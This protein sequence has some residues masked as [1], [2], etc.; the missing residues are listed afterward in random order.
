MKRI[1][2]AS[3]VIV[4]AFSALGGASV[5]DAQDPDSDRYE[6]LVRYFH[7]QITREELEEALAPPAELLPATTTDAATRVSNDGQT[8]GL[9][10][11]TERDRG[12]IFTTGSLANNG[13][14]RITSVTLEFAFTG[15]PTL[16]TYSLGLYA[17]SGSPPNPT[18]SALGTF[19]VSGTLSAGVNT[20]TLDG[21]TPLSLQPNTAYA[22]IFDVTALAS[23]N[24][25]DVR[26]QHTT[27]NNEDAGAAA[28]WSIRDDSVHR[29]WNT[30]AWGNT[31]SEAL[32]ISVSAGTYTP[33]QVPTPPPAFTQ[34]LG[35]LGD[36]YTWA[37]YCGGN[38]HPIREA[39]QRD[40]LGTNW[41][42]Y[43]TFYC[44]EATGQW[45]SGRIPE[46]GV[47]FAWDHQLIGVGEPGYDEKCRY[48]KPGYMHHGDGTYTVIHG[49][50]YDP[51]ADRCTQRGTAHDR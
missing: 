13:V 15:T 49:A 32:K 5:A 31:Y 12:Q 4:L 44:H 35:D 11:Q 3:L 24:G 9:D 20:F 40:P 18:G 25:A 8:N 28:G 51:I 2:G 46:P 33:P 1:I 7:G 29:V 21:N 26:Y 17:V 39:F 41:N 42:A 14:W 30:A 22:L 6:A 27:S 45:V 16:P 48:S 36:D 43:H 38:L 19:S 10:S 47:D 23:G 34:T 37:T 50:N